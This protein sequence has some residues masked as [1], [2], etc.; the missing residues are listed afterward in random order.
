ML[1][2]FELLLVAVTLITGL[3]VFYAWM[4]R[5]A[6]HK[7]GRPALEKDNW[8]VDL[9]RSLFPVIVVVLVIRSFVVEPFRIPSGSM[10]PTLLA[11]DFILVN[12]FSYDVRLP[13]TNHSLIPTGDPQRGDLAVFKYPVNP[14]QDFIKRVV[15][16]PG[17][18]VRYDDGLL[19]INDEPV[20]QT[21]QGDYD[22]PE[23]PRARLMTETLGER[24]YGVLQHPRGTWCTDYAAGP[25]GYTVPDGHYFTIGDNRDRSSDS[26]CWGPVSEDLL[27]GRAFL[28]WMS[29]NGYE[30]R[31][32]W[33]R[34]GTRIQ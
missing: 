3:T 33:S 23:A 19:Y 27:V 1:F 18:H 26:R 9:C 31:I 4:H 7:A 29:W 20:E 12:K 8:W 14:Q 34:I 21:E 2:D 10:I 24:E 11:G 6:R 15:A 32:N 17:D 16:L 13:V 25:D 22:Q 28:I 5:R 30:N